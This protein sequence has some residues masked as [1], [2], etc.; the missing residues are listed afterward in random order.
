MILVLVPNHS[1]VAHKFLPLRGFSGH[2]RVLKHCFS[3]FKF[4]QLFYTLPHMRFHARDTGAPHCTP[5]HP[6]LFFRTVCRLVTL[7]TAI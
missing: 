2:G 6:T 3:T 7:L 1:S 5:L 4:W